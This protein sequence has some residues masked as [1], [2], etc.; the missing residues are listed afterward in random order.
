VR[1]RP[2]QIGALVVAVV[3]VSALW[4]EYGN[5][6][7]ATAERRDLNAEDG[8]P[9]FPPRDARAEAILS[10]AR[11]HL[12]V[13]GEAS[14]AVN[15]SASSADLK[16]GQ[17]GGLDEE[18]GEVVASTAASPATAAALEAPDLGGE[19]WFLSLYTPGVGPIQWGPGLVVIDG[20]VS[21]AVTRLWEELP[22]GQRIP[23]V[24]AAARLKLDMLRGKERS[25]PFDGGFQGVALDKGLDGIVL[26]HPKRGVSY[27]L[28]SWGVEQEARSTKKGKYNSLARRS[29]H[30]RARRLT[31]ER[32][33]WKKSETRAA[34]FSAFRTWSWVEA[35][36]GGG[37]AIPLARGNAD[38]PE[39]TAEVLAER[40]GMAADYLVRETASDGRLTYDYKAN[41][42]KDAGGYNILRHAG[43]GY[44]MFQAYRLSGDPVL[45]A[46][47][48]RVAG[49]FVRQ[50]RADPDHPD[51]YFV[52]WK[53]RR[54]K[55]GGIGLG[56][57]MLVEQE[58]ASP[59]SVDLKR[60]E[61]M[62]RHIERMQN[63]DGSFES[64]FSYDDRAPS[65]RKSIYYSGEAILGLVRLHQLSGD[66]H[67][68]EVAIKGADYL[69][70]KRWVSL[71][72]RIYV[73]PD[74]WLLQ[75][76]EELDRAAPDDRRAEYAFS[77][78]EVI[79]GIK[80]MDPEST[81]PDMLGAGL[82]GL[83]RLPNSAT[84]GSFGEA[85][86]AAARL[87]KRRRPGQQRFL[88]F[89]MNNASFQLRNQFV[90]ANSYYLPNPARAHGGFRMAPDYAEIRNDHVQH[91]LSGM[92][93]LL[94]ILDIEA[95]DIGLALDEE[96]R[97]LLPR[98]GRGAK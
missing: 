55:L 14:G 95:P 24:A 73:P 51:E 4:G 53:R 33:G 44:S 68:L 79:A 25:F 3:L 50:M 34:S 47:A 84:A 61:G 92:F 5:Q 31:K 42:D 32:L 39:I 87:E 56:L 13:V 8:G 72:L 94:D 90:E 60:I 9:F 41:W 62:A 98:P 93:G 45:L 49:F 48:E 67:W 86:T 70:N 74:A 28:P 52:V 6:L 91:N 65:I 63:P 22:L 10:A 64:F 57:C 46:A 27:F 81:P 18:G 15:D 1:L 58:K 21:A 37:A 29:I 26:R 88:T 82:S 71:G 78:G 38:A 40:I 12:N 30:G 2:V 77:I 89:A 83:Q 43:T 16:G 69:V 23:E 97:V 76:L 80:L 75:A 20:D 54:A 19:Q 96:D 59:G 66:P 7:R 35:R 85:L 11:A 17:P 36:G